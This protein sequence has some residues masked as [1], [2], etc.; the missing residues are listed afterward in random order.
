MGDQEGLPW[1]LTRLAEADQRQV[2]TVDYQGRL[3]GSADPAEGGD[4]DGTVSQIDI[5]QAGHINA[6]L[7]ALGVPQVDMLAESRGAIRGLLAMRQHPEYYRNAVLD[8]PAGQ[9]DRSYRQTHIDAVRERVARSYRRL[10][11]GAANRLPDDSAPVVAEAS[12]SD[13][14]HNA[15]IQQKS[16]AHAHLSGELAKLD[17]GIHAIVTGDTE[18]RAFI[19]ARLEQTTVLAQQSGANVEFAETAWG[20][21]GYRYNGESLIES[22]GRL[23]ELERRRGQT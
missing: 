17:P 1:Y 23:R 5:D 3:E 13:R 16:V 19:A 2:I 12:R 14:L 10:K 20:G 7:E 22:L 4:I 15:R 6:A 8:H 9:D 11:G 21:H 18:D